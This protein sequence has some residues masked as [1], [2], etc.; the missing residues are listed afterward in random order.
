MMESKGQREGI[1]RRA[2]RRAERREQTILRRSVWLGLRVGLILGSILLSIAG[3]N[4]RRTTEELINAYPLTSPEVEVTPVSPTSTPSPIVN[5]EAE[6]AITPPEE[7]DAPILEYV[8]PNNDVHPYST[9]VKDWGV[10]IYGEGFTYYPIPDK[11]AMR[12]GM[13]PEVAQGYLWNTCRDA[14]VDY[15]TVLAL[16]ER[17]SGYRYDATG[18][19]GRSKGLMQIQEKWHRNRMTEL[20][21]TDLYNPYGNM[22]VGVDFLKEMQDKYLDKGGAHRVL[23]AYNMG[24]SGAKKLWEDGTY[25][26]AYS[27]EILQR[28][29]EIKQE[30]QDQ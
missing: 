10:E 12:G 22:K 23:M 19:R 5:V 16:I 13:F 24:A 1:Y 15:Y 21:V 6:E 25:S 9:I 2:E 11:Y 27:R 20:G 14:G 7:T 30:I 29:Q 8:D 26:T 17:E 28:A 4:D 3:C 18:D